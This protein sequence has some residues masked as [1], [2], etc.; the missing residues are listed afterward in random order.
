MLMAF[1]PCLHWISRADV[2]KRD[3][4]MAIRL[5]EVGEGVLRNW[6]RRNR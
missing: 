2:I 3:V 1:R 6:C 5:E 4:G